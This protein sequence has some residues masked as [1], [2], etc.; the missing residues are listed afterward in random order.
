[1]EKIRFTKKGGIIVCRYKIFKLQIKKI[2]DTN[3]ILLE[4]III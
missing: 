2:I 1:M 3:Y 4:K